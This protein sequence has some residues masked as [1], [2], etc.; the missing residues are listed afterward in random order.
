[1]VKLN[2]E[3]LEKAN[4]RA[5]KVKV[6]LGQG[7]SGINK[8][9]VPLGYSGIYV[10]PDEPADPRDCDRFPTSPWCGQNPFSKKPVDIGW[11]VTLN[12][13]G[14]R[15]SVKPILGFVKLPPIS[16]AYL[17]PECRGE[18][19]I[20]AN[21]IVIPPNVAG[22]IGKNPTKGF[23]RGGDDKKYIAYVG[24]GLQFLFSNGIPSETYS[25]FTTGTQLL[26]S[27]KSY[28]DQNEVRRFSPVQSVG[29]VTQSLGGSG[30]FDVLFNSQD[31]DAWKIQ[32]T[33]FGLIRRISN[34]AGA[35]F[36][37]YPDNPGAIQTIY[38]A[39]EIRH[40]REDL[41]IW[42]GQVEAIENF[43]KQWHLRIQPNET[44]A[45]HCWDIFQPDDEPSGNRRRWGMPERLSKKECDC[46]ACCPPDPKLDEILAWIK[47]V[48]K[49][50]GEY[51]TTMEVFDQDETKE[52]V[53]KSQRQITSTREAIRLSVELVNR[54]SKIIGID[55]LP[56]TVPEYVVENVD[57]GVLGEFIDWITPD[58]TV[59]IDSLMAAF[60][61]QVLNDS[62][63]FGGWQRL[64]EEEGVPQ[65]PDADGNP[66][67]DKKV[68]VVLPDMATTMEEI[69][70]L[71]IRT[72]KT[73][74]LI[75]DFLLKT[76]VEAAGIKTV[77]AQTLL[78]VE[79][80]QEYLDYP[81]NEKAMQVPI[82]L[83]FPSSNASQEEKNDLYKLQ[84]PSKAWVKYDD[85]TGERSQ[86]AIL[87][88]LLLV[89]RALKGQGTGV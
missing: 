63:V 28:I 76:Q 88:Q 49:N 72:Q 61:W 86:R 78:T 66:Q 37:D 64:V 62:A 19:L 68:K 46:M 57:E 21:P 59:K 6:P 67:P 75:T 54:L 4:K 55:L 23:G 44:V 1:M 42:F 3:N 74:G 85:W 12:E 51:P 8:G 15:A 32:M 34:V 29:T 50:L 35:I 79:D 2:Q 56:F 13:C 48:H 25:R 27:N 24:V 20:P 81:T 26:V 58:A 87:N 38:A 9:L 40:D 16:V 65:P 52:G 30:Y 41:T 70:R 36:E 69:Y 43:Y 71:H 53:Q 14:I 10:T 60:R 22:D 45:W 11:D 89:V 47:K 7:A 84:Q 39:N 83:T 77:A 80:I 82:Q 33:E 73:L 31:P 5:S 18:E 17:R